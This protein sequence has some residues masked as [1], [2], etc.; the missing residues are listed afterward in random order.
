MD[1]KIAAVVVTYNRLELLKK[2]IESLRN[3]TR[4]PDEIIVINNSST[5]GTLEWLTQQQDLTVITQ[6]NSGSAGG[7]Y[8][9][10]STAYEKGYDWIWTMD[11][12]VFANNESLE[13]LL[14][15]SEISFCINPLK[16]HS[17]GTEVTWEHIF[18]PGY[19]KLFFMPNISFKNG[20]EW[21]F[22]N[23]VCFEGMLIHREIV[24]KIGYPDSRF[25]IDGDDVI[26]G[27]LCSLYTNI[28][29]VKNS[30][31]VKCSSSNQSTE[32]RAYYRFRNFFLVREYLKKHNFWKNLGNILFLFY[33]LT[34]IS[35][36]LI[37]GRCSI[38]RGVTIGL[39]DGLRKK[40]YKGSY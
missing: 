11:E 27:F 24:S 7:Q 10:I 4:K 34:E 35:R 20:K 28:L 26:Y 37:K 8:T 15:Y 18:H 19:G 33:I 30:I 9:G 23:T 32:Q 17:D 14:K 22:V 29:Y 16:I 31:I 3:Q 36:A 40:F 6:E 13:K 5:D 12:D 25:F 2:C 21:C 38:V 39:I 1:Y